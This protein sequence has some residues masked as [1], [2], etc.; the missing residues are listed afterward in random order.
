MR[1]KNKGYIILIYEKICGLIDGNNYNQFFPMRKYLF[2]IVL[3]VYFPCTFAYADTTVNWSNNT[4]ACPDEVLGPRTKNGVPLSNGV[5]GTNGSQTCTTHYYYTSWD[6]PAPVA[7]DNGGV[8]ACPA[9]ERV[10]SWNGSN[11]MTCRKWDDTTPSIPIDITPPPLNLLANSTYNYT[12][13]IS[14]AWGAPITLVEWST[15]N[16]NDESSSTTFLDNASP[17]TQSW[18]ISNVDNFRKD[19]EGWRKYTFGITKVCDEAGNCWSGVQNYDHNVYSDTK[20]TI[21][22]TV[23]STA[24]TT[25]NIADGTTRN[26]SI[27]LKDQYNNAIVPASGIGRTIDIN[28]GITNAMFLDQHLRSW[29]KSVFVNKTTDPSNFW[30]GLDASASFDWETSSDGTYAYGF[31]FYTPTANQTVWKMSDPNANFVINNVSYDIDRFT[32]ITVWDNPQSIPLLGATVTAK[33]N[34]LYHTAISGDLR[35][36]GFIEGARQDSSLSI[37]KNSLSPL[38]ADITNST[39]RLEFGGLDSGKFKLFWDTNWGALGTQQIGTLS[40]FLSAPFV[41]SALFTK[42]V[43]NTWAV[44]NTL[45]GIYLSSHMAY[46]LDGHN[47]LYNSDIV[48]KDNFF[49]ANTELTQQGG[50]KILGLVSTKKSQELITNQFTYDVRILGNSNKLTN[51]SDIIKNAFDL[52]TSSPIGDQTDK[53]ITNLGGG[54]LSGKN[55]NNKSVIYFWE[56]NGSN[57]NLGNT[58]DVKVTGKRTIL[59]IWGNLYIKKNVYYN[60]LTQDMLGIVVLKDKAGK[61]G[62]IYIDPDITNIAGTLFAEKSIVSYNG[63]ELDGNTSLNTLK[64]QLYIYGNIFSENTIGGSRKS[65]VQCPFY[66]S[67]T[68]DTVI[69]QKY[70]LNYLRRY[71]LVNSIYPYGNGKVAGWGT[72]NGTNVCGSH[73]SNLTQTKTFTTTS[74]KYASYPV[75]IEYNP[76]IQ[77]NPPPLFYLKP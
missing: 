44:N 43:Q 73:D 58:S 52:I 18:N 33:L 71:Y 76:N 6:H 25:W 32:P 29:E 57:V 38:D 17:W 13:T 15:E 66:V 26:L 41:N 12:V 21:T 72:C 55:L 74:D 2:F 11:Q 39:V 47:V 9:W 10:I 34:P 27:V 35:D 37:T 45:S 56:L 1:T 5:V 51:K 64:N 42:L 40:A 63:M 14:T 19:P 16:S 77:K 59:I 20:N 70:D 36:G 75:I 65:P 30:H 60:S 69:A 68:C 8:T 49:G 62:N 53:N 3:F 23:D 46:T 67:G 61:G 22:K 28:W 31:K 24:L 54:N 7:Y 50:L 48:G 4:V